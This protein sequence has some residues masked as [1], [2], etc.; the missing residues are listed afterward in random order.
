MTDAGYAELHCIS[1]F[2]FLRGA[3]HP[4]ELVG[5]AARLGYAAL[6]ITDECSLG[7]IVRAHQAAKARSLK[8][9]VGAEF[10]LEDGLRFVLLVRNREGYGQLCAFIT[11]GRRAA[12]K[13]S[14]RLFRED[15]KDLSGCLALWLP[16][17]AP[18][19]EQLQFMKHRFGADLWICV[20]RLLAADDAHRLALLG[21]FRL[22][23]GI[24]L[25][26]A[27]D[28]HM[29]KRGRRMLQDTLTSIRLGIPVA[30]ATASLHPNGERHLRPLSRLHGLYPEELRAQTIMIAERCQFSLDELHY[31]YPDE[32]LPEGMTSRD[33]LRLLVEEGARRRWPRGVPER[34]CGLVTRELAIIAELGYEAY[35][36]TVHGIVAFARARGILCQGRG[37]AA[38]SAVCY[39][40]GVTEVDP[41]RIDVLFERFVSRE[42]NEPPDIDVD[43]EHERREEVIQYLFEKY[44]RDRAAMTASIITYRLRSALRDVAK[45]LGIEADLISR[46]TAS[47]SWWDRPEDL[48]GRFVQANI[49]VSHPMINRL[50]RL[51]QTLAGFPRHLSQ[52]VGGMVLSATPL[53]HMVPI[54]NAAMADRTVIQWDKNDL[55]ALGLLKIDCLALGMLT[56]IR[57]T[58]ALIGVMEGRIPDFSDI[59]A[60]DPDVYAMMQKADTVV[61]SRSS[62]A[63]RWPCC[64]G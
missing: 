16:G 30:A 23:Y 1:N 42:R 31:E 45:A 29:H 25:V 33:Y 41:M 56:A 3:S 53:T 35:F 14:Y 36:L 46:M 61:Y 38:N 55:D 39:C 6:A 40:L 26:A 47:I 37:S 52:H 51:V 12:E 5:E 50:I 60:E 13:G 27:S 32:W 15:L 2:T 7:G 20:E 44:G 4:E 57:K 8:L 11:R 49:A 48:P 43:F 10:R 21:A 63:R 58:F 22:E 54:E 19:L 9:I 18:D 24:P 59:P 17:S 62:R 34:I 64:R 28:I